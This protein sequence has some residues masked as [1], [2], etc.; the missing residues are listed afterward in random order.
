MQAAGLANAS[1]ESPDVAARIRFVPGDMSDFDLSMEFGLVVIGFRSFQVLHEPAQQRGCLAAIHRHLRPRGLLAFHIFD[2]LLDRCAPTEAA[3]APVDRGSVRHPV[4]GNLVSLTVLARQNDPIRQQARE[5][6]EFR[7]LD[8]A[9]GVLRREQEV[10]TMRWTYRHEMRYLLELAGLRVR[11]EWSDFRG[12]APAYGKE[13]VWVAQRP[14]HVSELF[15]VGDSGGS[16]IARH[17]DRYISDA[18][19]PRS[20]GA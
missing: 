8:A 11:S 2:P 9:G 17:K 1:A 15:D 5:L 19:D 13:Q 16:D 14:A 12:S 6:W 20:P 3:S 10:L 4:S 7:E 18:V